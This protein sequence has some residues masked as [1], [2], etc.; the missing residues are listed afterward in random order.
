MDR[1]RTELEMMEK[2]KQNERG[3]EMHSNFNQQLL[4]SCLKN[5]FLK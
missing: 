3:K 2:K 5:K 1:I 4:I